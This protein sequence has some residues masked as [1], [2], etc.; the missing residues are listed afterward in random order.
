MHFKMLN[1]P[2]LEHELSY[3][4][5]QLFFLTLNDQRKD[6]LFFSANFEVKKNTHTHSIQGITTF[7]FY[8]AN[9]KN[10]WFCDLLGQIYH[11]L[12]LITAFFSLNATISIRWLKNALVNYA[13]EKIALGFSQAFKNRFFVFCQHHRNGK[14]MPYIHKAERKN[15]CLQNRL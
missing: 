9:C 14:Y 10:W 2:T 4:N 8:I 1:C 11:V 12:I 3:L 15:T 5:T 6:I 13:D 7:F